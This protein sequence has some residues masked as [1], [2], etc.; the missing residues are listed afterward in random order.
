[1]RWVGKLYEFSHSYPVGWVGGSGDRDLGDPAIAIALK[2][3]GERKISSFG[4]HL[5]VALI[6]L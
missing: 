5:L 4:A 3:Y 1:M 6:Y 2:K